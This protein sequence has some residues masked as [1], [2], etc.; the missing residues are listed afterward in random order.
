MTE[1]DGSW[2]GSGDDNG[3]R[4]REEGSVFAAAAAHCCYTR[5]RKKKK[6]GER[7]GGKAEVQSEVGWDI[8]AIQVFK[9][10]SLILSSHQSNGG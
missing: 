7:G 5:Q 9:R 10:T 1:A 4:G 2:K 3:E 8:L 6:G